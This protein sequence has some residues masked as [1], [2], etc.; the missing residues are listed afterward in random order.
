[1][2]KI[3]ILGAH[4]QIARVA[5]RL[6]LETTDAEL[7]LYLR[8][9]RR[10]SS[11]EGNDRV[12]LVE[13]DVLDAGALDAAMAGQEVVYAN[14]SGDMDKQA[15]AIVAAMN[16]GRRAPAYLHQLDGYL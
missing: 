3:L 4:G 12:R 15:H 11:L 2:T 6:L 9:A 13:G 8:K 14:L 7:T 1:M 10:L 5:T 16:K